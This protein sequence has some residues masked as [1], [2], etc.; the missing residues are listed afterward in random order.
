MKK[1]SDI[2]K[3]HFIGVGGIG[4]SALARLFLHEG[5]VVSGSDRTP[6]DIT[7]ALETEGVTFFPEQVAGNI[8]DGTDL[9]VYTEAMPH[10]HEELV[11]ARGKGIVCLNYFEALG[12]IAN[13][14]YLIAVAGSHGKTTTTA[15]LIDIFED[16]GLDPTA[17][18][19]SLRATTKSNYRAGKSKYFIVEACEYKRDF[20]SLTPDILVVTNIEHEHVDYYKNLRDVQEAFRE[21]ASQVRE[22]GIVVVNFGGENIAPILEGV[23]ARVVDYGKYFNPLRTLKVP[24]VHNQMN[25]AAATAAAA[26]AG[27]PVTQADASLAQ[28]AGTWRRFEY[29]GTLNGAPVYDDYGHHPTEIEATIRGARE[30][31]SDKKLT[32]V[33]QSHTYSRTH[34]LF[35]DFTRVLALA[36][37]TI[38]LPIYAA[39]EENTSGVSHTKL[40]EAVSA[41][42]GHAEPRE[43]FE[44]VTEE[45]R[46]TVTPDDL[47]LVMGAGDITQVATKLVAKEQ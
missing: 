23:T 6:S 3:A 21:F 41:H 1:L 10:D 37:R 7:R 25:A 8:T 42:S 29:K 13:E 44:E 28:F 36:D 47:I 19:G 14:Y 5:K 16:A 11:C 26:E 9:V 39:R 24:G 15:M 18:V 38:I 40:A 45:L 27:I 43:T 35:D 30:M 22:G 12:M 2:K 31:Y 32:L 46:R 20:L 33:F 17:I 34:V 4:M